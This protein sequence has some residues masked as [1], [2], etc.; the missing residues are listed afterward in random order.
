MNTA[1]T[2]NPAY[3]ARMKPGLLALPSVS[4]C[5]PGQPEYEERE[6]SIEILWPDG[7]DP[8]Q[9]NCGISRFGNAWTS[10]TSAAFA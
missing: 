6:G 1:I 9:V 7:R 8:V 4:I 5:V 2:R 10:T 3:A